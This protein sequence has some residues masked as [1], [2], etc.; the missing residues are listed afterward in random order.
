MAAGVSY[1]PPW[2]VSLL[3]RLPH[4]SLR[5]EAVAD[6]FRPEDA[7]YQQ[8]SL[9]NNSPVRHQD[10]KVHVEERASKFTCLGVPVNLNAVILRRAAC[11]WKPES[12]AQAELVGNQ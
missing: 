6:D 4:F 8:S 1:A 5:W 2:W 3:H 9:P 7:E 11:Y 12:A 10:G